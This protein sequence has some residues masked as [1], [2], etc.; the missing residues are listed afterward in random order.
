LRERLAAAL[1]PGKELV[2]LDID[3]D[4]LDGHALIVHLTSGQV[5]LAA[6]PA[7]R[8]MSLQPAYGVWEVAPDGDAAEVGTLGASR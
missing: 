8:P 3:C 4:G 5:K 6:A 1:V 7:A 2:R